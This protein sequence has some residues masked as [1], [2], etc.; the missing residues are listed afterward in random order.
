[1]H[2][3][4]LF[5]EPCLYFF[6]REL[7]Y[8]LVVSVFVGGQDFGLIEPTTLLECVFKVLRIVYVGVRI[9]DV[10][11]YLVVFYRCRLKMCGILHDTRH[12]V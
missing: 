1:M 9:D 4:V 11:I 8:N 12:I 3:T 5:V 6:F 2:H 7:Q 10:F